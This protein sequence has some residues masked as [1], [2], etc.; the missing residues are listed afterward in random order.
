MKRLLQVFLVGLGIIFLTS[1]KSDN[2]E[3]INLGEKSEFGD[4]VN[5]LEN[6]EMTLNK[7][8]YAS[9]G[10]KFEVTVANNSEEEISFGVEYV[11][12]YFYKDSWYK[13]ESENE[14]GFV[15]LLI[16]LPPGEKN[17]DEINLDFYEPLETGKY[18]V[19]RNIGEYPIATEFEVKN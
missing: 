15:L 10:D 3:N 5:K 13:V 19:I 2:P 17:I 6:V 9:E 4:S 1:C 11:L 7:A 18:R 8:T 16:T 12:E 14:P